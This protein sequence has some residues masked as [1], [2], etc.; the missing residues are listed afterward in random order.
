MLSGLGLVDPDSLTSEFFESSN[1]T[2]SQPMTGYRYGEDALALADFFQADGAR[3]ICE[4]CSGVAVISCIIAS[5][6]PAINVVACE[7]QERLHNI[8]LHNIEKNCLGGVIECVRDDYR[9]FAAIHPKEF[10]AIIANPPY[11]QAGAGRMGDDE[12][13][14]I[15]RHELKGGIEDLAMAAATLL[16][17]K[18]RAA[19]VF[20][21]ARRDDLD[22][23]F[24]LAGFKM[25]RSEMINSSGRT[26]ILAQY[27][28]CRSRIP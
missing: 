6:S 13:R 1:I 26:R 11:F 3:N 7:I 8:A 28:L 21:D 23:A 14:N 27:R 17:P 12:E 2:I 16:K 20:D 4:L 9:L 15:A 19:I 10:D 25:E 24:E 18:G 22:R 5:R